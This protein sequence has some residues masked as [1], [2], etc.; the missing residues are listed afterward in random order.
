METF[1]KGKKNTFFERALYP[2]AL[3]ICDPDSSLLD[4]SVPSTSQFENLPPS[5]DIYLKRS[6]LC[7]AAHGVFTL[8]RF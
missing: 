8:P 4:Q 1:A 5:T 3:A 2:E 7:A 6:V